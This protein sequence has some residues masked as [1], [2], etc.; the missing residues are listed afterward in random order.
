MKN[1]ESLL[2][3]YQLLIFDSDGT[4]VKLNVDW[5]PYRERIQ[6]EAQQRFGI[7]F[8]AGLRLDEMEAQVALQK[9]IPALQKLLHI[10]KT[11]EETGLEGMQI[12]SEVIELIREVSS[13]RRSRATKTPILTVL[14]NNLDVTV[15][16]SLEKAGIAGCFDDIIGL[17]SAG[18]RPKPDIQGAKMILER[19]STSPKQTLLI[20]DSD[21]TDGAVARSLELNYREVIW[22]A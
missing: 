12:N 10:R 15:R 7:K 13:I 1:I 21:K 11:A 4:I 18:Y 3:N 9:G 6:E 5:K 19:Y 8:E 16:T 2:R 20:G 22:T 14:S 17:E